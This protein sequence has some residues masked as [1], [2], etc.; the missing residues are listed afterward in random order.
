MS[1][2]KTTRVIA[3]RSSSHTSC[4]V[5]RVMARFQAF[6]IPFRRQASTRRVRHQMIVCQLL[7]D[8]VMVQDAHSR[9]PHCS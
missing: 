7:P 4:A 5:C 1:N 2:L 3:T 9:S 6:F 8:G